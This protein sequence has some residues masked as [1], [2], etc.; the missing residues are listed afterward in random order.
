MRALKKLILINNP[1]REASETI[2]TL[3]LLEELDLSACMI[4]RLPEKLGTMRALKKLT[5]HNN[6]IREVPEAITALS[7]LEELDLSDCSIYQL[8]EKFDRLQRL[9]VLKIRGSRSQRG[10][11]QSVPEVVTKLTSLEELDLSYNQINQLPDRFDKLQRLKVLKITGCF[12]MHGLLQS[13][14]EVVTKLTSLEELDL[15]YN[16]I[17][18]LPDRLDT[19]ESLRKL[20]LSGNHLREVPE[21]ITAL[22]SL[23]ELDLSDNQISQLPEK[24]STMRSLR[25]LLLS[26]NLF[27]DVPDFITAMSSLEE[28]NLSVCQIRQLPEKLDTMMSL[29]KLDL[30]FNPFGEVPEAIAAMSLL[31]ELDLQDCQIKQLPEKCHGL[32]NLK[33]LNLSNNDNIQSLPLWIYKLDKLAFLDLGWNTK[34]LKIESAVLEMKSLVKLDCRG[35]D[36][37]KEPPYSVCQQGITAIRKFFI[38]LAAEKP[39]KLIE[40]PVAVIGSPLSGKT[41]L[42][43]TLKAGKR[44]LT[45]REKT[46][47]QDETTR[48]FQVKDLPLETTQVKLFD[49]G[50]N[51]IYHHAYCILSKEKCIPLIVVDLADFAQRAQTEGP[52]QAC[53]NVCFDWLAHL[54]LACPKLGSPILVLTH[55]D[56]LTSDQVNQA[57]MD[58]LTEAELIRQK[59][60]EEENK[61]ESL[62][63]KTLNAIKHLSNRQLP[64]F[65]EGEIFEFGKDLD[66]T[67][68]IKLLMKNLNSRCEDHIIELPKLWHSVELFIK[69]CSEQPYV[70]VSKVLNHFPDADP[71]IVLRY[72]HNCGRLFFFE[73]IEGL[74]GYIFH[75]FGEITSMINLLFHHSSQKQ[76]NDHLTKF[77][78]FAHQG[79]VIDKLE[80]EALVQRLLHNGILAE[81]LLKNLLEASSFSFAVSVGLLESFLMMHGPFGK[82]PHA[83]FLVPS[84]ASE[85][86]KDLFKIEGVLRVKVD[87]LL[88][89]L[90]IPKYV[91][92][93]LSVTVLN[94]LSNPLHQSSAYKNGV[95]IRHG[96]SVTTVKHDFNKKVVSVQVATTSRELG[97][98]WQRLINVADAIIQQLSQSWK[99]CH[100][101]VRIYCSHCMFRGDQEPDSQVNPKWLYCLYEASGKTAL[102]VS[103]FSGIEPVVCKEH[104][105]S[106][107]QVPTPLKFPC[108]QLTDNEVAALDEY[109]SNLELFQSSSARAMSNVE[110]MDQAQSSAIDEDSDL[111]DVEQEGYCDEKTEKQI[112]IRLIPTTKRHVKDLYSNEN[113]I[114]KMSEG[115]KGRA[116][117]FN[118]KTFQHTGETRHGSEVDYANLQRLLK[119]LKFDVAKTETE[120]TD[121]SREEILKKI[122]K[123]TKREEHHKLGMFVLIIMSHGTD[124]DMILDHHGEQFSLVSIRDSLSPQRFPAMAGKP[125]LIIV[126]ACSGGLSDYGVSHNLSARHT[127]S[128]SADLGSTAASGPKQSLFGTDSKN[129]LRPPLN[130]PTVLNVDDF[131]I[132]KA[133]SESYTST[134]SHTHGSFFIRILVYTFYKHACHRDVESLFKIIQERVRQV[135]LCDSNY[136]LGGNVPTSICTFTRRR[137]LFLF[138]GY[139]K[140]TF[141][142]SDDNPKIKKLKYTC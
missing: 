8:P 50:G 88:R 86:L 77:A 116:L 74:S 15:S 91:H 85:S 113:E 60:L 100:V 115:I 52:E 3:S 39:V 110:H 55:T 18:W 125:K 48:V 51:Q 16:Q 103:T 57:R 78:C 28:L 29:R 72:M 126:Q 9:K 42:F 124:G 139:S 101:A 92:Q 53:R 106:S 13:L 43:K 11:L 96:N 98:S 14:P 81:A 138:P 63:P 141:K 112:I 33:V 84:L 59:L 35:N 137:K 67:S 31:E 70:E 140:R 56:E 119:D 44:V 66:V 121:L 45:Y 58:L 107:T 26:G 19:M 108:F 97:T 21:N 99:A 127:A 25:R 17:N 82:S 87:I 46:S 109:L 102:K 128:S 80:Y 38:D 134:R 47:E 5:L 132:M 62:S 30:S 133:S 90:S 76:W 120:H 73:K 6:L 93:Q 24:L 95:T 71:L 34:L 135:S 75:R 41:S 89:G 105:T 68:N 118:I 4:R 12:C 94:L 32:Q 111:S 69:Q 104:S 40:V 123:E 10:S 7:L 79:R 65:N 54:Y 20:I 2:T 1:I 61:L 142:A 129:E 130:P 83:E 36:S 37:L 122:E 136:L 64:L 49:Y 22:S 114:Y 23:E 27:R 131:C 117:I